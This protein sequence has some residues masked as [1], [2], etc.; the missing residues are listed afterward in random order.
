MLVLVD[1]QPIYLKLDNE[2]Q[3]HSGMT[4]QVQAEIETAKA[5]EEPIAVILYYGAGELIPEFRTM[6]GDYQDVRTIWKEYC[7]GSSNLHAS[8]RPGEELG[9]FRMIGG[10]I[11]AC[12]GETALGFARIGRQ[13]YSKPFDI[14]VN[15]SASYNSYGLG[16]ELSEWQRGFYQEFLNLGIKLDDPLNAW[17]FRDWFAKLQ[18]VAY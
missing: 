2:Q 9:R 6:L 8:L 10:N 3:W 17:G 5:Q 7:D 11:T 13:P 14:S 1:F 16:R 18:P 12:L 15:L 4:A